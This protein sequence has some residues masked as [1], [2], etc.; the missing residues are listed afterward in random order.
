M[1]SKV[2]AE[3]SPLLKR[4][5]IGIG[6]YLESVKLPTLI[7]SAQWLELRIE[8]SKIMSIDATAIAQLEI[9]QTT[10][11]NKEGSLFHFLDQTVTGFGS[12]LLRRWLSNPLCDKEE[13]LDRQNAVDFFIANQVTLRDLRLSLGKIPD[14][15]RK[16]QQICSLASQ[17]NRSAV[18]FSEVEQKRLYAFVECLN[19]LEKLGKVLSHAQTDPTLENLCEAAQNECK[20]LKSRL[21]EV[22][23][24]SKDNKVQYEPVDFALWNSLGSEIVTVENLLDSEMVKIQKEV[25]SRECKFVHVKYKYEIECP[26]TASGTSLYATTSS[27]K[28][29]VRFQPDSIKILADRIDLLEQKRKDSLYPFM[30]ELFGE[31]Q[32]H[33]ELFSKLIMKG[34]ELDCLLCLALVS[35]GKNYVKP[36][37]LE[38]EERKFELVEGRHPVTELIRDFVPNNV[39]FSE[40]SVLLVTGPNM[41]GKSTVLRMSSILIILAQIGCYVP[42]RHFH[43]S[44]VDKLFARLGARDAILEGKSTFLVE[45]EET[46]MILNKA[47]KYSFAV[48]DELGRGTS[49]HDGTAIA[50]ATLDYL[51][52]KVQCRCL[53]ST[54]YHSVSV[55][56]KQAL[57]FM[58]YS[59]EGEQVKFQY[60][61]LKGRAEKSHAL[62]VARLAGIPEDVINEAARATKLFEDHLE[63]RK[64]LA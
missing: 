27:R 42:A 54:H 52:G 26:S 1:E 62:N 25:G 34:A 20:R 48:L 58:S 55:P 43:L 30:A 38:K 12:R 19:G 36:V 4:C 13:I 16:V 37:I 6:L 45:L 14:L 32:N 9:F 35:S 8:D 59:L 64:I 22:P 15:E 28:G 33:R 57:Y 24:T 5:C 56:D 46:S 44:P 39:S 49:T 11:G 47:T 51:I 50:Q 21:R 31:F 3:Y 41:G 29:F 23:S 53:F 7:L 17:T 60:K 10:N 61:F 2:P 63:N 40:S 18:F